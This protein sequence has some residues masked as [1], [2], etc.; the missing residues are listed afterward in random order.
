M[1]YTN[2]KPPL[3]ITIQ[4]ISLISQRLRLVKSKACGLLLIRNCDEIHFQPDESL[5]NSFE[6]IFRR[7]PKKFRPI[8]LYERE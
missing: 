7:V 6:P 2:I 4:S 5:R 8:H 1:N 3:V